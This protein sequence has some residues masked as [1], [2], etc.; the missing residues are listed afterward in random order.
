[1]ASLKSQILEV[2]HALPEDCT[3]DDFR[4]RLYLQLK[5]QE[6]LRC[7]ETG[8]TYTR[9]EALRMIQSWRES[10]GPNQR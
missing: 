1:M 9:E 8:E 7:I 3:M 6:G 2:A 10:Y 4:D 5:A